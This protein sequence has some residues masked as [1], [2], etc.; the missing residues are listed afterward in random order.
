ME[1]KPL[2]SDVES[3][4]RA[5]ALKAKWAKAKKLFENNIRHPS[6]NVELLEPRWRGIYS[7]RLD[8]TYRALFFIFEGKAE[9]F[10]IT[11]HYKK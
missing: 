11:K 5:H 8:R 1:I 9:I 2:R 3:S 10:K 4:I 7:F 6:L